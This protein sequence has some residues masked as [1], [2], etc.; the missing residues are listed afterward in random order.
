MT[1]TKAL[2][3]LQEWLRVDEEAIGTF[4]PDGSWSDFDKFIHEK[5]EALKVAIDALLH[6]LKFFLRQEAEYRLEDIFELSR[7]DMTEALLAEA[8]ERLYKNSEALLNT[9]AMDELLTDV[10]EERGVKWGGEDGQ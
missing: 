4:D 3:V 8:A 5:D 1:T 10:L 9:E 6:P 7:R 2:E